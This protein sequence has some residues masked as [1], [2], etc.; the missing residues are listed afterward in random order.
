MKRPPKFLV[1]C[2]AIVVG[3]YVAYLVFFPTVYLRYRLTL[4]VDVDGV[5][6][7]G[8]GVVEIAYQGMPDWLSEIGQAAHF[9]GEMHGYAIP[10]DLGERGLL[11]VVDAYPFLA[12]PKTHLIALPR[13]ASLTM[14]PF[15]A[16]GFPQ[17]GM[18]S[19][20][21][22]LARKLRDTKGPVDI[23][24]DRLPMV[25]RFRN[26]DDG[27]T[28]EE[29]DPRDLAAAYGPEVR[30]AQAWFEFTTD[31]VS[32]MPLTWPK[33]LSSEQQHVF[34]FS[35]QQLWTPSPFSIEMFKRG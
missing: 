3:L 14:L 35:Y 26:I 11:F 18:P 2:A 1:V 27:D 8:S 17:D 12:D 10:V 28:I 13:A 20:M 4:D 15:V 23:P 32:P 31:P 7:T 5:M 25:V 22:P 19:Y 16:Y 34:G 30:L 29:L 24:P 21:L 6:R 9:A 33:W